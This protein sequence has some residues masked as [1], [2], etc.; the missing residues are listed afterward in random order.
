[1]LNPTGFSPAEFVWLLGWHIAD[2]KWDRIGLGE[3]AA[4][5]LLLD[6]VG[7]IHGDPFDAA[8]Q[9]RGRLQQCLMALRRGSFEEIQQE[10]PF[11][12]LAR[13]N[14]DTLLL[15][16][17]EEGEAGF[18]QA[19]N[20]I[21]L[22]GWDALRRPQDPIRVVGETGDC[23]DRALEVQGAQDQEMRVAAEW[24]YLY[25]TFGRSWRPGMHASTNG[26]DGGTHFS[27]HD[28]HILPNTRKR[29]YFRLPW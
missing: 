1:M 14:M 9:S 4:R 22:A 3:S 24:W 10:S 26:K 13:D 28:I 15:G 29:I 16:W 25:Y 7:R 17:V 27:V 6:T 21:F 18:E 11:S 23:E 2:G 20:E 5:R 19:W 12:L 8:R